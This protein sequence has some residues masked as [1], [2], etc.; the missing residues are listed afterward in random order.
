MQTDEQTDNAKTVGTSA[1]LGG[2]TADIKLKALDFRFYQHAPDWEPKVGD[3][4]C[5]TRAGLTLCQI[6][7]IENGKITHRTIFDDYGNDATSWPEYE[8]DA[9]E[10]LKGGFMVNRCYVP[11]WVYPPNTPR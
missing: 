4:Y 6:A 1:L 3:Y 5:I 7:K 10:F 9:N 2:W 11:P 8:W